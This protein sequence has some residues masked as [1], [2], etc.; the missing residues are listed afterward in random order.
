M[1]LR[2][3]FLVNASYNQNGETPEKSSFP[4][5][6]WG[7]LLLGVALLSISCASFILAAPWI[8]SAGSVTVTPNQAYTGDLIEITLLGFPG[9]YLVPAGSITLGGVRIPIPGVFGNEGTRPKTNSEGDV[10]FTTSVPID[11]P[12]GP[13]QLKVVHFAGDGERTA[14]VT[15]LHA[16]VT[17]SLSAGSPNQK[18]MLRG[19]GFNPASRPGGKGILGVHQITGRGTSGI[20]LNGALLD[21]PYVTYPVNLD[22]DGGLTTDVILPENYVNSPGVSLE[23]KV[24]DDLGRIGVGLWAVK[25]R[26]IAISPIE[27]GR[28]SK[29][30]V[31]G[32]GF[33]ASGGAIRQ[34]G[35]VDVAYAGVKL[36]QV[37]PDSSGSF[38][39][40]IKV[41][42]TSAIPST[43]IVAATVSGCPV[44]PGATASH[45]VP[46]RGLEVTPQGSPVGTQVAVSGESFVGF[47]SITA[48]TIGASKLSVLPSPRPLVSEDGSFSLNVVIPTIA[49]GSQPISV[50]VGGVEYVYPFVV[51]SALPTPTPTPVPTPTPTLAP[52]P[53]VTPTPMPTTLPT[54]TP[55]PTPT[56]TPGP[57]PTPVPVPSYS[58]LP[59]GSNLVRVWTQVPTTGN[60]RYYDP[61]L[62]FGNLNTLGQMVQGQLYWIK[63]KAEQSVNLNERQRNLAA[64]W[65]LIHW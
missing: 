19:A 52:T 24:I 33:I 15:V 9:D 48:M 16:E 6:R 11:A 53:T 56:P 10:T 62:A 49:T 34:C 42:M 54:F 57:T 14:T 4:K 44:A 20:T 3:N 2:E 41:P 47:T 55:T 5:Y 27:S 22:S 28:R 29:L 58:L 32:V 38:Q 21:A 23:V 8:Q 39:T 12:F 40:T 17:F 26:T 13:Q 1:G 25:D 64:G 50:T 61:D 46:V 59:L 30:T 18:V 35:A 63:V 51:T 43:N 31:S 60:W 7:L 65:N 45:K 37:L 36:A